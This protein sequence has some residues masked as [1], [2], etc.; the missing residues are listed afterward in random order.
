MD[1]SDT[2][3]NIDNG[4]ADFLEVYDLCGDEHSFDQIFLDFNGF[5][6]YCH[7]CRS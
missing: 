1:N 4:F 5:S 2:F 7:K 6:M 3:E